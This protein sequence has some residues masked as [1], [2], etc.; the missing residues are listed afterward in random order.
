MKIPKRFKLLGIEYT[1][2]LIPAADWPEE[3]KEAVGLFSERNYEIWVLQ[4]KKKQAM[5]QTFLHEAMHGILSA[6]GR[7]DLYGNEQFIDLLASLMHQMITT[8][9]YV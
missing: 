4:T 1:V 2:K 9:E 3:H 6:M 7:D 5:E 8:S